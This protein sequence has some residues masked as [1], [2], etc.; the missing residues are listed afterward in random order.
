MR[1]RTKASLYKEF[2]PLANEEIEAEDVMSVLDGGGFFFIALFGPKTYL[3]SSICE[4]YMEYVRIKIK[5]QTAS[6]S[7]P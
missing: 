3:F 5:K 6:S 7:Y 2:K 1:K 4:A